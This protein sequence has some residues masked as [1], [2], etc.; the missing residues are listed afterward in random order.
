MKSKAIQG[1]GDWHWIHDWKDMVYISASIYKKFL[2]KSVTV[3]LRNSHIM[4][5]DKFEVSSNCVM[6]FKIEDVI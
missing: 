3:T 2:F 5:I 4:A 6:I 1:T